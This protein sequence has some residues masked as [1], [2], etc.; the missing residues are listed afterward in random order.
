MKALSRYLVT[1]KISDVVGE[2]GRTL[3]VVIFIFNISFKNIRYLFLKIV[4]GGATI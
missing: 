4:Q 3:G 1:G 2:R